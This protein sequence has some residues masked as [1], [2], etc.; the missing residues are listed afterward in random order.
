MGRGLE[1]TFLQARD[2]N[3]SQTH[4]KTL[5]ITNHQGNANQN[6]NEILPHT[7]QNGCHKKKTDNKYWQGCGEKGTLV[8]SWWNCKLVW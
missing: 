2:T 4:G 6:F 8:Y 5:N 7:C 3:G 1:Q